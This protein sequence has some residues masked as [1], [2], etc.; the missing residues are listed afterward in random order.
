MASA[1]ALLRAAWAASAAFFL[2]NAIALAESAS[3]CDIESWVTVM[4]MYVRINSEE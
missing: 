2:S 4:Q 3:F 1:C